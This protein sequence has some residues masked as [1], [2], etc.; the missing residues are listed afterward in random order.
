[1]Q[2]AVSHAA[3]LFGFAGAIVVRIQIDGAIMTKKPRISQRIIREYMKLSTPN[4]SDGLDRMELSGHPRGILA[5]WHPPRKIVGPAATMKLVPLH[6]SKESPVIGTLKAIVD[7]HPGDV[8]VID[9]AGNTEVNA[10]GGV[11]GTTAKKHGLVGCVIDG[12]ARDIDEYRML[13]L[14]VYAK[15][16]ICSSIRN[17]CGFAGNEIEVQLG[18]YKV[19]PG[20]LVCADDSGTVIVPFEHLEDVLHWSKIFKGVEDDIITRVKRGE[21]PIEAHEKVR[22]DMMTKTSN[23]KGAQA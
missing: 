3:F 7:A 15:G 10:F 23:Q 6:Q 11:A 18:G 14:P 13:G 16:A 5:L 8:L 21:D 12:V 2:G 4:I 19:R 17:R 1:M 9:F 22:Y 20:D